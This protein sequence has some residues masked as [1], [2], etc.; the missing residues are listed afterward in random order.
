LTGLGKT[1]AVKVVPPKE[2]VYYSLATGKPAPLQQVQQEQQLVNSG[3]AYRDGQWYAPSGEYRAG[4]SI[5]STEYQQ[6]K[7]QRQAERKQQWAQQD[8][9]AKKDNIKLDMELNES[10]ARQHMLTVKQKGYHIMGAKA[11]EW[12]ADAS[13]AA[14][15]RFVPGGMVINKWY[16][17]IKIGF[18]AAM[19]GYEEGSPAAA[20]ESLAKDVA[21]NKLS[22]KVPTFVPKPT[23]AAFLAKHGTQVYRGVASAGRSFQNSATSEGMDVVYEGGKK[24]I[25]KIVSGR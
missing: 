19:T 21:F 16:E 24:I 12:V 4:P 25:K 11:V 5:L 14:A 7:K 13:I 22:K 10:H 23:R 1:G 6:E 3:Y 9:Q 17:R 20:L 15:S 8:A 2:P 18:R